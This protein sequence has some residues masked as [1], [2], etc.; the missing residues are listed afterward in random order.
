MSSICAG[1]RDH[2][3]CQQC[4][5]IPTCT[6]AITVQNGTAAERVV[7]SHKSDDVHS[8]LPPAGINE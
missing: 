6:E 3:R 7:N 4:S 8:K 1:M 2:Q 5:D